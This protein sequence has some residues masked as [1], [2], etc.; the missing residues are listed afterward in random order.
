MMKGV[1]KQVHGFL[2]A[3][4]TSHLHQRDDSIDGQNHFSL[5]FSGLLKYN[6]NSSQGKI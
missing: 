5:L 1:F 6:F 4:Q 2:V 3:I